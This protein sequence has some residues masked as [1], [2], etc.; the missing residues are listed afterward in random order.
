VLQHLENLDAV[1]SYFGEAARVLKP[2]G[3][4]MAHLLIAEDQLP[5]LRR[6]TREVRL[7]YTR[8]RGANRGAYSRVRR[9]RPREVRH[10][11]EAAG[12]GNV[13]LREFRV[14]SNSDPHAFWIGTADQVG[15]PAR[16]A[17]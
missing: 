5:L 13:E 8:A 1:A 12:F 10:V 11:M 14:S 17:S 7:R 2:G 3:T 4:M 15:H 9:Y 6:A 16:S